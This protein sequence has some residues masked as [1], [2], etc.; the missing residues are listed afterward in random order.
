MLRCRKKGGGVIVNITGLAADWLDTNYIAGSAGNASVNAF[1]RALGSNSFKGGIRVLAIS[2]G[3]VETECLDNL[4]KTKEEKELGDSGRW[5]EFVGGLPYGRPATVEE[6]ANVAVF[7]G[8]DRASY[9][10][11]IV[12][13][14]DGGQNARGGAFHDSD[15]KMIGWKG[16][17]LP[18]APIMSVSAP[19]SRK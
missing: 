18:A 17:A 1:S 4:K 7:A 10:S 11:G 5:R 12:I 2:P 9:L 6:V 16:P 8:S 14:V 3:A 15:A 13:S 19:A